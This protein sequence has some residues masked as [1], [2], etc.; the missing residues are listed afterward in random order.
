MLSILITLLSMKSFFGRI[1]TTAFQTNATPPNPSPSEETPINTPSSTDLSP[2]LKRLATEEIPSEGDPPKTP[3]AT[4]LPATSSISPPLG[5][6][7]SK[8]LRP[9]ETPTEKAPSKILSKGE[10]PK[11]KP[12]DESP[13]ANKRPLVKHRPQQQSPMKLHRV[14]RHRLTQR[15][16]SRTICHPL[17]LP[18]HSHHWLQV[19]KG[20]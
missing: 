12:S 14:R 11:T 6:P 15:H 17:L 9:K 16:R 8:K 10:S 5:P 18:P 2:S 20:S 7:P 13:T 3:K 19:L 1:M 4:Q